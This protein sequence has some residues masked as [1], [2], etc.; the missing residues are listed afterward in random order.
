MF[1]LSRMPQSLLSAFQFFIELM[2]RVF[3]QRDI[4]LF[5]KNVEKVYGLP[6]HSSF[7]Q[8][9]FKQCLH[10]QVKCQTETI[11]GIYNPERIDIEGGADLR[12]AATK[13][14]SLN[15]GLIVVTAHLGSWEFVAKYTG[16]LLGRPFFALAKPSSRPIIT[17]FLERLR[18]RMNTQV[19]WT[20]K[21]SLLKDMIKTVKSGGVLGFVMDQKPAGRVGPVAEFLGQPTEFV[22]GPANLALKC[23]TPVLGVYCTRTSP[24]RYRMH[25]QALYVPESQGEVRQTAEG[26][27][28]LFA[29]NMSA[30]IRS[31]PEQWTW[32]Y[33]RWRD[34]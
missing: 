34:R 28:E 17:K 2:I 25:S 5:F 30:M 6:R 4:K 33:K 13:L 10:H 1:F 24:W 12:E 23:G 15:K 32:S 29:S 11:L 16:E 27:T 8:M 9:F 7:A 20:G 19:L 22:T 18:N 21:P 26:L 14:L 3:A 31:F